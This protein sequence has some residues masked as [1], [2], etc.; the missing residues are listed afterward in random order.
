MECGKS[1]RARARKIGELCG[2]VKHKRYCHV[3]TVAPIKG[4]KS[5]L[6][7]IFQKGYFR[8]DLV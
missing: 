8:K 2:R 1:K 4:K 6:A 7:F 3:T 5:Q